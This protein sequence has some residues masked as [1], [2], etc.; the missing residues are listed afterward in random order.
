MSINSKYIFGKS[1]AKK[2][3]EKQ[4]VKKGCLCSAVSLLQTYS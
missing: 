1:S 4:D 3:E 2:A